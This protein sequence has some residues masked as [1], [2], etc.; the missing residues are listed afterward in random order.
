MGINVKKPSIIKANINPDP[1]LIF[2]IDA[3]SHK[4]RANKGDKGKNMEGDP[5]IPC[6]PNGKGKTAAPSIEK[7]KVSI[8]KIGLG[9]NFRSF[10][11]L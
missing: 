7:E 4:I 9:F 5:K 2:C 8:S 11:V 6:N 10:A 3:L 1:I